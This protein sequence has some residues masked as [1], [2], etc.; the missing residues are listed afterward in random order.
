MRSVSVMASERWCDEKSTQRRSLPSP[1]TDFVGREREIVALVGLLREARLVTLTGAGGIG[2]TRLA[3]QVA[4]AVASE[5]TDGV[6]WVD[7]APLTDPDLICST[8]AVALGIRE[9]SARSLQE[10][11]T[12]WL[13]PRNLVLIL[14]NCEHLLGGCAALIETLLRA[15]PELRILVTSRQVIGLIGEVSWPVPPL[16]LPDSMPWTTDSISLTSGSSPTGGAPY[17]CAV[18][19]LLRSEA[20]RLFVQRARAVRPSFELTERNAATVAELCRRLDG[21]PLALELAAARLNALTAE[22]IVARLGSRFGLLTGGGVT[23]LPRHRTL[24]ALVDW[25]HDLLSPEEQILFR[26]LSVFAGGWTLEAVEAVCEG[27]ASDL[28]EPA[29]LT[30]HNSLLD[31]LAGLVDKSL[32]LAEEQGSPG[33][34]AVRYRMLETIREYSSER[35]AA[36]GEVE[37]VEARHAAYFVDLAERAEPKLRGSERELWLERLDRDRE[38]LRSMERRAAARGDTETVLRL[39]AALW[40]FWEQAS[41]AEAREHVEAILDLA[42]YAPPSKSR[43][44]ALLGAGVLARR[45]GDYP[46]ARALAEEGLEVARQLDYEWRAGVA[47]YDLGRLAC[48]EGRYAEARSLLEASL[49][50]YQSLG[51]R[52]RIAATLN[53]LGYL[54]FSE[55]DLTRA[56]AL[57]EQSLAIARPAPDAILICEILF[58]LGLTAHFGGDLDTARQFYQECRAIFTELSDRPALA[59]ALHALGHAATMQDDL[60]AARMLYFD[61]LR[62]A[63]E[64]GDRRRLALIVW[65]V[66]T[67][68]AAERDPERAVRLEAAARTAI[69]RIGAVLPRPMKTLWDAQVTPSRRALGLRGVALAEAAGRAMTLEAVVEEELVWLAATASAAQTDGPPEDNADRPSDHESA[70]AGVRAR[71]ATGGTLTVREREVAALIARGLSNHQIADRLVISERTVANHV[72]SILGGLDFRNRAQVAAWVV[73]GRA[74]RRHG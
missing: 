53:R 12:A 23:A 65:A 52:P 68:A 14:D 25:S 37:E 60:R 30:T 72:H 6:C 63:R 39:G 51:Y 26:R 64:V 5:L 41:A 22:Q 73:A 2:K 40:R 35:L 69:E 49:A 32:V 43:V 16:S 11:L 19:R 38:N 46:A 24:A 42:A 13:G 62:V 31:L 3:R 4:A 18:E 9:D 50:I 7:L 33:C 58:N 48:F 36:S 21:I 44:R 28:T 47:L 1:L 74:Q 70:R 61:G 54:A 29:R 56:R 71:S 45:L 34:R 55:G 66:A 10:H 20:G 67:L 59:K 8:V 27:G 17:E 57:L 15:A